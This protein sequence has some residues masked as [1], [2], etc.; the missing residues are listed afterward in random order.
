MS[1]DLVVGLVF[2]FLGSVG[3]TAILAGFAGVLGLIE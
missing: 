2:G 3:L 1:A